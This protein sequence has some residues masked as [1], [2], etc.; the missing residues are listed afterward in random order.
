ML[1][2]SVVFRR[3]S[4]S[5]R[6][7]SKYS[8]LRWP[9]LIWP[10]RRE[11]TAGLF[12]DWRMAFAA[13]IRAFSLSIL[14]WTL[15]TV[16]SIFILAVVYSCSAKKAWMASLRR[17]RQMGGALQAQAAW[18]FVLTPHA[19]YGWCGDELQELVARA[20]EE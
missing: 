16:S 7:P 5:R 12:V 17:W 1:F 11:S 10:S 9:S 6:V 8:M 20:E 13:C 15:V 3:I 4:K 2:M 18:L 19:G 14:R